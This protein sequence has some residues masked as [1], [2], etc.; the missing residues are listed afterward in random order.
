VAISNL[1]NAHPKRPAYHDR[2]CAV[3]HALESLPADEA[4]ALRGLLSDPAWRYQA[5]SDALADDADNPL[6]LDA[7]TLSRHARGRCAP[8]RARGEKLR[9]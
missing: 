7:D 2:G 9:G 3:C 1:T 5:L 4:T 8:M 6:V